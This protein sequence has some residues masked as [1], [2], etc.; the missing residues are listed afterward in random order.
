MT[1]KRRVSA[2]SV[3]FESMPYRLDESTGLVDYDALERSAALFRPKLIIAG[4]SAYPRDFDYSRMRTI[5]DSVGAYLMSD[6]AHI[7]GLVA[8]DVVADPF[9]YSDVV[10]TTTHKSLRGPR[11]GK[12]V[13][14]CWHIESCCIVACPHTCVPKSDFDGV[15]CRHDIF[16][17]EIRVGSQPGRF[18]RAPGWST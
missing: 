5:A 8:A 17:E 18:P 15:A 3:Y 10:T 6:M 2:T 1:A 13:L 14:P 16:P 9:P 11:G 12:Q 7:S 4:A